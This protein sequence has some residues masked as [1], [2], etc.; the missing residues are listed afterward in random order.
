[1]ESYQSEIIKMLE[2]VKEL[3]YEGLTDAAAE[4]LDKAIARIKTDL[5][6]I[7]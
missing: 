2:D 1:M 4:L 6:D 3:Q 5:R 7:A